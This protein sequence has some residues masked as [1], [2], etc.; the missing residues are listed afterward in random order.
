MP[1][2]SW[3]AAFSRGS[4]GC[5]TPQPSRPAA[6][7]AQTTGFR[8]IRTSYGVNLRAVFVPSLEEGPSVP[9]EGKWTRTVADSHYDTFYSNRYLTTSSMRKVYD[10]IGTVPCE[11]IVLLVNTPGYGGGGIFNSIS[12][13]SS[14]DK[15]AGIV[16]VHEFGHA[17]AGL[18]DEY[19]YDEYEPMYPADTEPWEPNITTL[20]DFGSKWEDLL[21]AEDRDP[22]LGLF[23]GAGNSTHGVYRPVEECRMRT[24]ACEKF[25]PVC[26]RAIARMIEFSTFPNSGKPCQN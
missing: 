6:N 26:I 12:I 17:F 2:R 7:A 15:T 18:A 14:D 16:F 8:W 4:R 1:V 13:A 3:T 10:A 19:A 21:Q 24:N 25:C 9:H 23:E 20:K 5:R 22:R 11:H